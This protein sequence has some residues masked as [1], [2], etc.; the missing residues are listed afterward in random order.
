[1]DELFASGVKLA[2]LPGYNFIFEKGDDT[3]LIKVQRNRVNCQSFVVCVE[4]AKY[5][6]NASILLLDKVAE[7]NYASGYFLAKTLNPCCA[8]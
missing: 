8:G 6:K 7:D 4:W 5:Q 3:E 2:Y 1:M